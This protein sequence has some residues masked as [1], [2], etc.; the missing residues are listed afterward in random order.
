MHHK[1]IE[2]K[3]KIL[4]VKDMMENGKKEKVSLFTRYPVTSVLI[5][6]GTTML[7]FLLGGAGIM[8]GYGFSSWAGYLFGV[9]YLLFSFTEMYIVMP[10]TV[11]RNCV[12]YRLEGALCISGLNILSK[13]MSKEGDPKNFQLRAKGMFCLNNMY[14]AS[15]VI[16]ILAVL[17]ALFVNFSMPLLIIFLILMGLMAFRFFVIFSRIAC[18]H[19]RAKFLCPQ[20]EQMGVREL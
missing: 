17:A 15:L 6:N 12:Y 16:P 3:W 20:A 19:C 10:L 5:Y 7:H 11:C 2:K 13:K 18:I 8:L 14:I 1:A 4:Y 9:L